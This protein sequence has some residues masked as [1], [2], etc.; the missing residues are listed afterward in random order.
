MII[1]LRA[2]APLQ[3]VE[4]LKS[5]WI[6]SGLKVVDIQGKTLNI[7]LVG[8]TIQ[9]DEARL[10]AYTWIEKVTRIAEPFK[11]TSRVFHPEDTIV[12]VAG[13]KFGGKEKVVIIGGPCSVESKEQIFETAKGVKE[14]GGRMLRGGAYKPRTS[15]YSFQVLSRFRASDTG[16]GPLWKAWKSS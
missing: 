11:K 2:N 1:T 7:F 9:I 12:D 6:A 5:E 10:L 13:I 14:S 3:E 16:S 4:Q 8:D 15:P